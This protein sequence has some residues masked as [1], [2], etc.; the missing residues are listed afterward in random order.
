MLGRTIFVSCRSAT[1][2]LTQVRSA[3][4]LIAQRTPSQKT[5]EEKLR[6]YEEA[7]A[8]LERER[9]RQGLPPTTEAS[10]RS[11]LPL[12]SKNKLSPAVTAGVACLILSILLVGYLIDLRTDAEDDQLSKTSTTMT[13]GAELQQKLLQTVLHISEEKKQ[14]RK[15]L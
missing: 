9:M 12:P 10:T 2:K 15:P 7:K 11:K 1:L 6:D 8:A 14:E 4:T 13:S 3:S 5:R